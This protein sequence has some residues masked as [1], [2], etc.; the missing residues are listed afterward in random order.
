MN[1]R[2]MDAGLHA[3]CPH[4]IDKGCAIHTLRQQDREDMIS[5][6]SRPVPE[7]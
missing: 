1:G 5:W 7:G 2:I 3:R 4:G 6:F